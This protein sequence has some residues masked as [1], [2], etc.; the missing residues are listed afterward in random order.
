MARGDG[1]E[2]EALAEVLKA[3]A[4]PARI[5]LMELLTEPKTLGEIDLL[6]R[7]GG[8]GASRRRRAA[9]S[10]VV[11]HLSKLVEVGLVGVGSVE[12]NGREIPCYAALPGAVSELARRL[13]ALAERLEDAPMDALGGP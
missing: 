8:Q 12:R 9:R 11:G 2:A 1:S 3:L 7:R 6:P 10:T 13:D 4:Y 5:E